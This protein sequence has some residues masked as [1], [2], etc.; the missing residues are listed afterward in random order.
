MEDDWKK[1][2]VEYFYHPD[3]PTYGVDGEI[4]DPQTVF[5]ADKQCLEGLPMCKFV[6]YLFYLRF[7]RQ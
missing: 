6:L 3:C 7:D 5:V 1:E 2:N 4:D